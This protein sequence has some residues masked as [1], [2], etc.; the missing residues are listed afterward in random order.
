MGQGRNE[1]LDMQGKRSEVAIAALAERQ[2]GLITRAQLA[3]LGVGGGAIEHRVRL[4]RL[5]PLHRGVYAV[6][7]R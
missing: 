5:H 1:T 7:Q 2:Y 4:H 6:G 3:E